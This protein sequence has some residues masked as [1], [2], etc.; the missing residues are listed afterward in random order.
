MPDKP[1]ATDFSAGTMRTI[2]NEMIAML[3]KGFG[4]AAKLLELSE[5]KELNG[6][7][8][9]DLFS[10]ILM[11]TKD[12]RDPQK[13]SRFV[14]DYLYRVREQVYTRRKKY[15]AVQIDGMAEGPDREAS[16]NAFREVNDYLKYLREQIR[17]LSN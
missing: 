1:I 5:G 8:A 9:R 3:Y 16:V 10:G 4:G 17:E 13:L 7:P 12:I 14:L 2:A 6:R 15:L 11:K